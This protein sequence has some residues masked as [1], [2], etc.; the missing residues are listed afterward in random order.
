MCLLTSILSLECSSLVR[1]KET[2]SYINRLDF[3][4]TINLK[5][6]LNFY[7]HYV[8]WEGCLKL[9]RVLPAIWPLLASLLRKLEEIIV[10]IL[11]VAFRT[12]FSSST[13]GK[14]KSEILSYKPSK[15]E[16]ER[17]RGLVLC[18]SAVTHIANTTLKYPTPSTMSLAKQYQ[19]TSRYISRMV[20]PHTPHHTLL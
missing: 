11:R 13:C 5:D 1:T 19:T 4:M 2:E 6:K 12:S 17:M 20:G 7:M 3:I 16:N 15:D 10:I 9:K 14:N 18:H 8:K